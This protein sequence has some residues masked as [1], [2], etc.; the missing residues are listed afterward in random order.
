M[1]VT[2]HAVDIAADF[3][4]HVVKMGCGAKL[5]LRGTTVVTVL[6]RGKICADMLPSYP[7]ARVAA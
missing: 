7:G 2:V 1:I 4:C 3:G 6:G 5:I